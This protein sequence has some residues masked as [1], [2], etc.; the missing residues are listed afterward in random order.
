MLSRIAASA[1][2]LFTNEPDLIEE[3]LPIVVF[4]AFGNFESSLSRGIDNPMS[5][6]FARRAGNLIWLYPLIM[7][8]LIAGLNLAQSQN[9]PPAANPNA[10]PRPLITPQPAKAAAGPVPP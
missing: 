5:K 9:A 3:D 1:G 7:I 4:M 8:A 10:R 2:S 6:T